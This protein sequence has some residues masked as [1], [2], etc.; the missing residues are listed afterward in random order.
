MTDTG[1]IEQTPEFT[2]T[3]YC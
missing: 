2:W 3:L 1:S